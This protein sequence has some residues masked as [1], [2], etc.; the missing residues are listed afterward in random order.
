LAH[1]YSAESVTQAFFNDIVHLH[2][3]PQSMV[4][5]RDTVFTPTFLQELMHLMGTKLQMTTP[6]HPQSDGQSEL[7]NCV[8][9]MYL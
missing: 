4:S 2:D 7:A 9:L 5:D 8:I 1:L 6:F 3:I